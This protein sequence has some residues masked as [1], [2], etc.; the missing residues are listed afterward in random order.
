MRKRN[1]STEVLRGFIYK[2]KDGAVTKYRFLSK[3]LFQRKQ[4]YGG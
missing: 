2:E 4:Q 1:V 3:H